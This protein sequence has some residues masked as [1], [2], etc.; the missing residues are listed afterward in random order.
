VFGI[1]TKENGKIALI[2]ILAVFAYN[3]LGPRVGL[4]GA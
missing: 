3:R 2:A 1:F 4:P